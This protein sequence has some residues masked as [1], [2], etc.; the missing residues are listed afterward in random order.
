MFSFSGELTIFTIEIET[1]CDVDYLG[2]FLS[3]RQTVGI[4]ADE[5]DA[6]HEFNEL[7]FYDFYDE[8]EEELILQSHLYLRAWTLSDHDRAEDFDVREFRNLL[9]EYYKTKGVN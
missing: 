6:L 7:T 2:N 4:Y 8:Q 5:E 3:S 1:V 9:E